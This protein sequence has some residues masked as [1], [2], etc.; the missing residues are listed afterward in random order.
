MLVS[1]IAVG[2][3]ASQDEKKPYLGHINT[4]QD[5]VVWLV[6]VPNFLYDEWMKSPKGA[7]LGSITVETA[8]N[9][10]DIKVS[11]RETTRK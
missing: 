7:S 11:Q 8:P 5:N 9:A 2:D 4:S 1:A 10:K 3:M 6:K